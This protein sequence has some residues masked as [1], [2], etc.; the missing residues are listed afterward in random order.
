MNALIQ[1]KV[2]LKN[3]RLGKSKCFKMHVGKNKSCC[4]NLKVHEEDMLT[5]NKEKYLG[6]IIL[7]DCKINSNI[8]ER[9][10]TRT[11]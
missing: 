1:S 4:P 3:L 8:E 2:E 11:V 5:S 9:Y 10:S 7:S 6:D